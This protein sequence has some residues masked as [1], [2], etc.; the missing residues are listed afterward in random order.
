MSIKDAYL[1]MLS[2]AWKKG[3]KEEMDPVD[4]KA[5]KKDFD[6]RDDKD[7][8]NDGDTDSSDEYLHKKRKAIS[9]ATEKDEAVEIDPEDGEVSNHSDNEKKKKKKDKDVESDSEVQNES[10]NSFVNK[11]IEKAKAKVKEVAEPRAKGE[12]DF[13]DQHIDNSD[14]MDYPGKVKQDGS[15]KVKAAPA[16]KTKKLKELRK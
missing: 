15:D 3:K 14:A 16:N 1:N 8:D 10:S 7:I 12:K 2:E 11:L 4:K 13:R 6:D 9:K 5:L